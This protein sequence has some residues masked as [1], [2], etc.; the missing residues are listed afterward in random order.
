M[1]SKKLKIKGVFNGSFS[2]NLIKEAIIPKGAN[3][4]KN[5]ETD[6]EL[7]AVTCR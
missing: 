2:G 4:K 6:L 7:A 5:W 1:K 3:W